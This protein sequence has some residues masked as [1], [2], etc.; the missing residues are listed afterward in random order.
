MTGFFFK[1]STE[2]RGTSSLMPRLL[3]TTIVVVLV[4]E[5]YE[6][7]T[8]ASWRLAWNERSTPFCRVEVRGRM[9]DGLL[10]TLLVVSGCDG[11]GLHLQPPSP[12]WYRRRVPN[13]QRSLL[14]KLYRSSGYRPLRLCFDGALV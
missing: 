6:T 12:C 8:I 1:A 11:A 4:V 3:G 14:L 10:A 13:P 9:I 5:N 2:Q 7:K